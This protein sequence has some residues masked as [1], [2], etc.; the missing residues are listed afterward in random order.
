MS[1][2][3]TLKRTSRLNN[4]HLWIFSNE[5][6]ENLK[7]YSTGSI[8]SIYDKKGV[9]YGKGYI[10]PHSLIT[11]R[12]LTK[13]DEPINKDFF[14]KRIHSAL[15]FRQKILKDLQTYRLFFSEADFLPGLIIDVYGR[16]VV[17]QFLTFGIEVL[18]NMI[19]QVVDELL[20][21]EV[22]VIRNDSPVRIIEGLPFKKEIYKG[23]LEDLPRINDGDMLYEVDVFEGQKTGFF[24]DQRF[25]RQAFS[26]LIQKG[27]HGLDLFCYSGAWGIEAL[28]KASMVTFTDISQKALNNAQRNL[29]LNKL[30]DRAEFINRDAFNFL[31]RIN[32]KGIKYDF[33]ILDPPA[34]A[35]SKNNLKEALEGYK[36]INTLAM[37]VVKTGGLI[38]TSS[39][40]H[41]IDKYLFSE[42]LKKASKDARRQIRILQYRGQ[43]I[44]HPILLSVPETE[45]LK[46]FFLEVL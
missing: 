35:K 28:K 36:E 38:A 43:A 18:A 46:C 44:D 22:I 3:I 19:L 1:D 30:A 25:N 5:I 10:N 26:R 32:D 17:L 27:S 6:V 39:C 37:S 9:F 12:I 20:M 31:R 41:H 24:L 29:E 15:L 13:D 21:P 42:I 45:Y 11:V 14:K 33:I 8:V 7:T 2:R 23:Q 16:V 40:S 4:G 34:F